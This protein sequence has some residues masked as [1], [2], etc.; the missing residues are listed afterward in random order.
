MIYTHFAACILGA[1]IAATSAWKVQA[2]RYD[3]QIAKIN[4][5]HAE[6]DA[7]R[8]SAVLKQAEIYRRNADDA[9]QKAEARASGNKRDADR[10]RR[11]LDGLRSD[12]AQVPARIQSATREAVDQ[13]AATATVVFEQCA[14]RYSG[15]AQEADG[16]ASD[17]GLL[18]DAWPSQP[19]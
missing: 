7:E 9:V 10:A 12:L 14:S 5:D 16:H 2:W 6:Q 17:V 4:Q 18:M 13:Y 19:R 8:S 1:V 3:T 15:L 11:E